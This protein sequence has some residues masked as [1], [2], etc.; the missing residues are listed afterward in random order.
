MPGVLSSAGRRAR[1]YTPPVK[2]PRS[3]WLLKPGAFEPLIDPETFEKAQA[4]LQARTVNK[5][6]EEILASVRKLLASK[7][8]LTH[9]LI[10]KC[11]DAP[12]PSTL[13][14]RFGGL[15]R[16]YELVGYGRPGQFAFMSMRQKTLAL[17]NDLFARIV[18]AFPG[19]IEAVQRSGR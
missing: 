10:R 16:V 7:G 8:K 15:R 6:D 17:R 3:Q 18:K 5:S 2:V 12:S 1:L 11:P 4:I 19:K 13:R 9:T 14:Y